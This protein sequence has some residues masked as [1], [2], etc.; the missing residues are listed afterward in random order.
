M[1]CWAPSCRL[2]CC[3]AETVVERIFYVLDRAGLNNIPFKEFKAS[4]LLST[5][6]KLDTED[7]INQVGLIY[8]VAYPSILVFFMFFLAFF[9]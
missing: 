6:S 3:V 5:L 9:G 4:K 1:L 8:A 2:T 7:D